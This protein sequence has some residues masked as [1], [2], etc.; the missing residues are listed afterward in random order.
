MNYAGY[1]LN[2]NFK[3]N[4]LK[5]RKS[6]REIICVKALLLPFKTFFSFKI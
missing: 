1:L 2:H 4:K 3:R 6:G 5:N